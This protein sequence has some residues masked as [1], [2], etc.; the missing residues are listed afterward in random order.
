MR[1]R[2]AFKDKDLRLSGNGAAVTEEDIEIAVS[3]K[4]S[5]K[6]DFV[7][8]YL[9][10]NGGIFAGEAYFYR[11]TFHK[12]PRGKVNSL[13]ISCFFP[14]PSSLKGANNPPVTLVSMRAASL[15]G[16]G[17]LREMKK[18][19]KTHIPF[20]DDGGGDNY[21]I[22]IPSGRIRYVKMEYVDSGPLAVM[23]IA[24]SFK[25]FV[26]NIAACLRSK[27]LAEVERI[28]ER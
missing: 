19:L 21:W 9:Q 13:P 5:G 7:H 11:D 10:H 20:A 2:I 17:H 27:D 22:E 4:F 16:Y 3:E 8:F 28:L 1:K 23:E 25:D 18:F 14:I 15:K 24:P 6:D 26:S 12:V